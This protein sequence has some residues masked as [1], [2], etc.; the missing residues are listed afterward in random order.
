MISYYVFG[1]RRPL[2]GLSLVIDPVYAYIHGEDL[3]VQLLFADD[4][5][6]LVS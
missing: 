2:P 5:V 3:K 4:V 6:L 1:G